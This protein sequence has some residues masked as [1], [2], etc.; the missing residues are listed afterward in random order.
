MDVVGDVFGIYL[1]VAERPF[2][3]GYVANIIS[4]SAEAEIQ[5]DILNRHIIG[6]YW[7]YP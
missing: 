6:I 7:T 5:R 2:W 1:G 3:D 4:V